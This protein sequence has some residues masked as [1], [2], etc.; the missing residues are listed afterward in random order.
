MNQ[1]QRVPMPG[2]AWGLAAEGTGGPV[3][4]TSYAGKNLSATVLTAMD[5]AGGV[6]W[7]REFDGHPSPPRV[8]TSGSVWVAHRGPAGA[9]LTELDSAG[10]TLRSITPEH[11]P[12]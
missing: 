9:V 1:P 4:V 5:V 8:N 6:L 11:E 7:H 2:Q 12:F 3:F 10:S